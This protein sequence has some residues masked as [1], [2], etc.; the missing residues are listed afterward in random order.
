MTRPSPLRLVLTDSGLG[1]LTVLAHLLEELQAAPPRRQDL[2]LVFFDAFP[3][4]LVGYNQLSG[5]GEQVRVFD[6]VLRE[7]EA[8]C[9]PDR[10]AIACNTLSVLHPSTEHSRGPTPLTE[11]TRSG[12]GEI[13]RFHRESPGLPL[14]LLA[15]DVTLASRAYRVPGPACCEVSGGD[16]ATLLEQAPEGPA[17]RGRLR[18]VLREVRRQLPGVSRAGLFLGC[19]HYG[20]A[21]PGLAEEARAIGLEWEEI[22]D[23]GRAM[24]RELVAVL[25][26]AC[27]RGDS[28]PGG[29]TSAG[30]GPGEE[31]AARSGAGAGNGR[32]EVRIQRLVGVGRSEV[33]HLSDALPP[34]AEALRQALRDYPLP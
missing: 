18:E 26:E 23:P 27:S 2:E 25:T 16:L 29:Q 32:V 24:A 3:R 20:L 7:L 33:D 6:Q 19:T 22:L 10:L 13:R 4:D 12:R 28:S 15:T 11:I 1:G 9:A 30:E 8:E 34:G 5:R 31:T 21:R 14:V 17:V